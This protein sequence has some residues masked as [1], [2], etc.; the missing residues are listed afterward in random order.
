L[1]HLL[2]LI[3]LIFLSYYSL[4]GHFTARLVLH[5]GTFLL[6]LVEAFLLQHLFRSVSKSYHSRLFQTCFRKEDEEDDFMHRKVN[7]RGH[8]NKLNPVQGESQVM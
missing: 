6:V 5:L 3:V 4:L 7:L 1:I 2:A 8:D